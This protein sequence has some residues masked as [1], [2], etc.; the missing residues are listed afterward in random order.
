MC[1]ECGCG[2]TATHTCPTCGGNIVLIDGKAAC[3]VCGSSPDLAYDLSHQGQAHPHK[4]SP[5][6]SHANEHGSH[7]HTHSHT[8]SGA[9]KP[10]SDDETKLRRLLPYWIEHNEEHADSFRR[11]AEV[12]RGL[13]QTA[14]AERM[15]AAVAQI[16]ACNEELRAALDWLK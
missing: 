1:K 4:H 9:D 16:V 11:W 12:A 7:E 3:L 6:H 15:E 14:V 5:G 13:G 10:S 2:L 8:E